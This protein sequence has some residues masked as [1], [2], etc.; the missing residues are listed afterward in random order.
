LLALLLALLPLLLP[1]LL[2]LLPFLLPLLL[3]FLLTIPAPVARTVTP[4]SGL[5][6]TPAFSPAALTGLVVA[7]SVSPAHEFLLLR[8]AYTMA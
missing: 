6:A 4:A 1:L 7:A 2:A 3:A 5:V 8:A